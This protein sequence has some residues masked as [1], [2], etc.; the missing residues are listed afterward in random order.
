MYRLWLIFDP[1]RTLIA[2]FTFVGIMVFTLHFIVLSTLHAD[3]LFS[4]GD[5]AAQMSSAEMTP[6]PPGR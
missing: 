1:R 6:L 2:L 3:W 5:T 4:M